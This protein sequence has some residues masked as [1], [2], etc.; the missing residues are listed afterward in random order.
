MKDEEVN[1]EKWEPTAI[2]DD[3]GRYIIKSYHFTGD[4]KDKI[5]LENEKYQ[6]EI[7]F[8]DYTLATR[9][10]EDGDR[11]MGG[12]QPLAIGKS[13]F[14]FKGKNS[15]F[16]RWFVSEGVAWSVENLVHFCITDT[17]VILDILDSKDNVPTITI[18]KIEDNKKLL[19]S[20]D[21]MEFSKADFEEFQ[22][23]KAERDKAAECGF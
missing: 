9:I 12:D 10:T 15:E 3:G 2:P 14:I 4:G 18:T 6:V 22:D 20:S 19:G 16:A 8:N 13:E 11:F 17:Y 23:W 7:L 1:W 5:I 21:K